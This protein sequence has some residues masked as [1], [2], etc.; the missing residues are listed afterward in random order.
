MLQA[1]CRRGAALRHKERPLKVTGGK[2]AYRSWEMGAQLIKGPGRSGLDLTAF[3]TQ[4]TAMSPKS[5]SLVPLY[6]YHQ[7]I[8]R[9]SL[10]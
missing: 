3:A 1:L 10:F 6:V 4:A 8:E 9:I 5:I 2:R 7:I